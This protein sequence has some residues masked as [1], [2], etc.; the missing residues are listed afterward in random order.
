MLAWKRILRGSR[1]LLIGAVMLLFVS[2]PGCTR[3][4]ADSVAEHMQRVE[5]RLIALEKSLD[6]ETIHPN[7]L[8]SLRRGRYVFDQTKR[9]FYIYSSPRDSW[10]LHALAVQLDSVDQHL[11]RV[12]EYESIGE[13]D[14]AGGRTAARDGS[15][16]DSFPSNRDLCCLAIGLLLCPMVV[17]IVVGVT[18]LFHQLRGWC[19]GRPNH[20]GGGHSESGNPDDLRRSVSIPAYPGPVPHNGKLLIDGGLPA[21][22]PGKSGAATFRR[23]LWLAV[24]VS[25]A[26]LLLCFAP[27]VLSRCYEIIQESWEQ[28]ARNC[29]RSVEEELKRNATLFSDA[30]TGLAAARFYLEAC[31]EH[32]VGLGHLEEGRSGKALY[33]FDWARYKLSRALE[34]VAQDRAS[35]KE[36]RQWL[37]K[38]LRQL[39]QA[40]GKLSQHQLDQSRTCLEM[41]REYLQRKDW[42]YATGFAK[43][44]LVCAMVACAAEPA[45]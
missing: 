36:S 9:E 5:A 24:L 40:Q 19:C 3:A 12:E 6:K 10:T 23:G 42:K 33:S 30:D 44:A 7:A 26:G 29:G 16:E 41:C 4:D 37:E 8:W 13:A 38:A 45:K 1:T 25:G 15:D 14:P 35:A 27:P 32:G 43:K 31:E 22:V 39:E 28:D 11:Q 18:R 21:E 2:G 20:S 17:V 34:L